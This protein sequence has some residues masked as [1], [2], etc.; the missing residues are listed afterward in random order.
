[1]NR[2]SH[3][4]SQNKSTV[5]IW[6]TKKVSTLW[7]LDIKLI[8]GWFC[9]ITWQFEFGRVYW[10]YAMERLST[11]NIFIHLLVNLH[12]VNYVLITRKMAKF[13]R[14][15]DR[16]FRKSNKYDRIYMWPNS[17]KFWCSLKFDRGWLIL[18]LVEFV[19]L[20]LALISCNG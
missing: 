17:V 8:V 4:N 19:Q 20:Y 15:L 9:C 2:Q 7:F 5:T 13:D 3:F 16:S 10:Q 6:K 18:A 1:M 11:I 14:F 12:V